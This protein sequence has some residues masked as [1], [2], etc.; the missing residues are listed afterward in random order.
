[1]T[2]LAGEG[3]CDSLDGKR[4]AIW[5]WTEA[6]PW[7]RGVDN[8]ELFSFSGGHLSATQLLTAYKHIT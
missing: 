3:P 4:E 1:M 2:H 5:G 8:A 6:P 7:Q